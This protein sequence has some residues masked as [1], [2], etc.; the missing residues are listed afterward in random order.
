MA[1][2][3]ETPPGWNNRT[4][5]LIDEDDCALKKLLR[6]WGVQPR[7]IIGMLLTGLT[8]GWLGGFNSR[9]GHIARWP[10]LVRSAR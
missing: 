5:P 6:R 7:L 2:P 4:E 1:A 8:L 10:F 9:I 3:D